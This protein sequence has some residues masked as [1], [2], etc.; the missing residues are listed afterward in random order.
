[1]Y[2]FIYKRTDR[3]YFGGAEKKNHQKRYAIYTSTAGDE[4]TGTFGPTR[5]YCVLFPS[6]QRPRRCRHSAVHSPPWLDNNA[7][8]YYYNIIIVAAV[9]TVVTAVVARSAGASRDNVRSPRTVSRAARFRPVTAFHAADAGE[10]RS[11]D[12]CRRT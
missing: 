8:Y 7:Y 10:R 12:F 11:D 4:M 2:I 1:M 6:V 9:V 5:C 3:T